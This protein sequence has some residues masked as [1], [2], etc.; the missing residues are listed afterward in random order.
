MAACGA[1]LPAS[2]FNPVKRWVYAPAI[3]W[4][5]FVLYLGGRSNVPA[6]DTTLP[7]DKAAHFVLYGILGLLTGYEWLRAGRRPHWAIPLVLALLVGVG[8]ELHQRSVPNRSPE[9]LDLVADTLGVGIGFTYAIRQFE[10]KR[11]QAG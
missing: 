1:P 4:G 5:A 7:L 10:R 2:I 3:L 9:L 8:D 6:V 11:S